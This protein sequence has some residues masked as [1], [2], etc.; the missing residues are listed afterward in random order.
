VVLEKKA[1]VIHI[2]KLCAFLL[3]EADF[4]FGNKM[5]FGYQMMQ[6]AADSHA[7]PS[8]CFGSVKGHH[9][10]HVSFAGCLVAD[11]A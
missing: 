4:N 7:I 3:M 8:E 1:G 10:I 11:V 2:D 5:L 6:Q 9:A